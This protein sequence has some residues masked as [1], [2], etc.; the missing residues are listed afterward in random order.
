[1]SPPVRI[2]PS[3]LS[4]DFAALGAAIEL[5]APQ[6][7]WLH[8]DVMDGHFVPNLTI[9]PPVVKSIRQH[10]DEFLD[11][12][13]MI[14]DPARYLPA[15]AEAGASSCSV[16]V[17]LNHSAALIA[18]ARELGIGIGIV[19]NPDTPF[20]RFAPFLADVDL[21]LLMTVFPGF[22]GQSFIHSVVPKITQ[23][24]QEIA[25]LGVSTVIQVDGGIDVH[26]ASLCAQAG[27]TAFVAGNAIFAQPDPLAAAA[28]IRQSVT[29][30]LTGAAL[31]EAHRS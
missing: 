15:F 6:T 11:C 26:T 9:G 12:H 4:A 30:A 16:H 28:A 3:I 18:Q 7:D 25:R 13:L 29:N 17:E 14:T 31:T 19:A 24:A 10:T 5:V 21:V 2:C 1:M 8:V 23:T 22:G 20:E 27:A